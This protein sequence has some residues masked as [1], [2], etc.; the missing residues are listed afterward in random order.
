MSAPPSLQCAADEQAVARRLL[1]LSCAPSPHLY[2]AA[3][4]LECAYSARLLR[5]ALGRRPWWRLCAP[6]DAAAASLAL[7]EY[8]AVDWSRA[9][10]GSGPCI[11]HFCVRK[12]LC[13]K[14]ALAEYA[15]AA[16][17]RQPAAL[18]ALARAL[19]PTVVIDV[20]AAFHGGGGGGGGGFSRPG[21][22]AE[23]LA[24]ALADAEAAI[25]AAPAGARWILKP[26]LANKAAGIAIVDG[27]AAAA[28][29]VCDPALRGVGVWVLQRY[30]AQPLTLRGRK[31][32]LRVYALAD[33]DLRVH[34][35][36]QA[37]A[38]CAAARYDA[39]A[40]AADTRVHIT[41]TCVAAARASFDE[42]DAVAC[43]TDLPAALASRAGG[44]A[45]AGKAQAAAIYARLC[46]VIADTFRALRAQAAAFMPL[47][48]A[49]ELY[50]V[51]FL[52]EDGDECGSVGAGGGAGAGAGAD[53]DGDAATRAGLHVRLLEFNP[54]PDIM[55]S[56]SRLE[57]VIAAMLE[58]VFRIAVDTRFPPPQQ[59]QRAAAPARA[60]AASAGDLAATWAAAYAAGFPEVG[61]NADTPMLQW[62][63]VLDL[64]PRPGGQAG[65]RLR[66]SDED[67]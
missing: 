60:A 14:A 55:Q 15:G 17:A 21:G 7:I 58:G 36:R 56:G 20:M 1:A 22:R 10:R 11:P 2:V 28:A 12:G 45:A 26:S 38:L 29:H 64:P 19:P 50:G 25:A 61:A 27:A 30:V 67:D 62:D 43:L 13:R 44:D 31:F 53:D 40:D 24:W 49:Y 46:V 63:C 3:I 65:M 48:H 35:F 23:A 5:G 59:E 9:L 33:G 18:R 37:L 39:A 41:N 34:V 32:H 6:A 54:T 66:E 8:E 52:V 4:A 47:A 51:D 42:A 16:A 57:F